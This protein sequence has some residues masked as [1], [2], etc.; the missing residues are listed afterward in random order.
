LYLRSG[1]SG[2]ETDRRNELLEHFLFLPLLGK[3]KAPLQAFVPSKDAAVLSPS[4]G[5]RIA[6]QYFDPTD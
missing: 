2:N 5:R 4:L 3:A 1:R 6:P